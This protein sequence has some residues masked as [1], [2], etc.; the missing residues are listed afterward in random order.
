[1]LNGDNGLKRMHWSKYTKV[2]DKWTWLIR[3][4]TKTKIKEPVNITFIRHST[5]R[6]DWD[7]LYSSFKVIGDGLKTAGVLEDDTMDNIITLTAK[8][9]K[10]KQVDQRTTIT[11]TSANI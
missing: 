10:S 9:E 2:R 11:I 8:W 3:Q 5:R 1:M 7:N 6:P 4:A